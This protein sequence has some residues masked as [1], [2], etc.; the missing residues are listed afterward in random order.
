M[1][2]VISFFLIAL[3]LILQYQLWVGDGS[4]GQRAEL[5][6]EIEQQQIKNNQLKARN[7]VIVSEIEALSTG[8]EGLEEI[9]RSKLG[10]IAEG[11]T[12]YVIPEKKT[13]TSVDGREKGRSQSS[14]DA[15]RANT[16][17]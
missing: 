12:F 6:K 8:T 17:E 10:M 16:N 1:K 2:L 9:A 5:Q 3:L 11:E 13:Q 14:Q 7:D 4:L 15:S